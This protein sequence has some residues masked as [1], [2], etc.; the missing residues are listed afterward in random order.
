MQLARLLIL[1]REASFYFFLFVV[2]TPRKQVYKSK[3]HP[4]DEKPLPIRFAG[5]LYY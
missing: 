5:G 1:Y 2:R 4:V 3:N